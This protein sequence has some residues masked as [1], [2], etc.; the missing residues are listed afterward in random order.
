MS[1][2][3]LWLQPSLTRRVVGSLLLAVAL[4]GV[5]LLAQNYLEFRRE[6]SPGPDSALV[7]AVQVVGASLEP[8]TAS[9]DAVVVLQTIQRQSDMARKQNRLEGILLIELVSKAGERIY[10]TPELGHTTLDAPSTGQREQLINGRHFRVTQAAAGPWRLRFGEPR[11]S[12][13][14]A[15]SLLGSDLLPSLLIAIPVVLFP[16]WLELLQALK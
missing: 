12:D 10:A 13:T 7:K 16:F 11:L 5:V 1:R 2:A 14:S 9:H 3:H 6:F 8:I 4:V 15:L